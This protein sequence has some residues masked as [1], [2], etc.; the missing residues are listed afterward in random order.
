LRF[1]LDQNVPEEI[2][3]V[4]QAL[5]HV[6]DH[7]STLGLARAPDEDVANVARGYDV[8]VTIDL[9]RQEA[10]WLAVT[11]QIVEHGIK[12]LR[13]RPP[14][15]PPRVRASPEW[16]ILTII[17]QLTY[18]MEAWLEAFQTDAVLVTIAREETAFRRRTRDEVAAI[19]NQRLQ[20]D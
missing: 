1:L 14:K 5:H 13:L 3:L 9:H 18:E 8:L 10:E 12:V 17:R 11:R 19:L 7:T 15:P 6:A 2:V 20:P 4:F 16:L